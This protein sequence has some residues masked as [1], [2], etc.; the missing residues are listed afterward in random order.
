MLE[1]RFVQ[2]EACGTAFALDDCCLINEM[3]STGGDVVLVNE[4]VEP[5][6]D[7]ASCSVSTSCRKTIQKPRLG[8]PIRT[9]NEPRV[10][11]VNRA[12]EAFDQISQ[13]SF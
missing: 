1:I 9:R 4:A 5:S 2:V 11:D 12:I 6:I 8:A 7:P 10:V 3:Q 13:Q